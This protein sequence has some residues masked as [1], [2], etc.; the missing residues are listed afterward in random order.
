M[1]RRILY[2]RTISSI[3]VFVETPFGAATKYALTSFVRLH[4]R[5]L[6]FVVVRTECPEVVRCTVYV[7]LRM[8]PSFEVLHQHILRG[9]C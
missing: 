3:R 6:I 5:P 9:Y 2:H 1:D 4:G 8:K 7:L